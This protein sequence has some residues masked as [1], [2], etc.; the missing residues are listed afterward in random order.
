LAV[1]IDATVCVPFAQEVGMQSVASAAPSR[2]TLGTW[3]ASGVLV[4]IVGAL[5]FLLIGCDALFGL[6]D[7]VETCPEGEVK[8]GDMCQKRVAN[9]YACACA[10]SKGLSVNAVV[11]ATASVPIRQDPAG[12]VLATAT[13]GR[14]GTI[15][16]G[17]EQNDLGGTTLTWWKIHW[18]PASGLPTLPDGWSAEGNLA[19]VSSD[20]LV[21]KDFDVC[22]PASLNANVGGA[23]TPQAITNDCE[24]RVESHITALTGQEIPPTGVCACAVQ[25]VPTTW[26]AQCDGQCTND[27]DPTDTDPVCQVPA[28]APRLASAAALTVAALASESGGPPDPLAAGVFGSVS[29]CQV[30]TGGTAEITVGGK[31]P[32]KQPAVR[33]LLQIHGKPCVAEQP[34]SVG[35]SYQLTADDIEFDSESIFASDPKFVELSV[36][37]ATIP[38]AINLTRFL[39]FYT[40]TIEQN[41]AL[42]SAR[43]RRSGSTD[44]IA[45]LLRNSL[46]TGSTAAFA[47]NWETKACRLAGELGGQVLDKNGTPTDISVTLDLNGTIVNQP[48]VADTSDTNQNVECT[49]PQGAQVTLDGSKSTDRDNNIAFYTWKQGSTPVGTPSVGPK[50]VTRQNLGPKTYS[51]RVVDDEFAADTASVTVNVVDT[52]KPVIDCHLPNPATISPPSAPVSFTATATD[53]CGTPSVV[54]DNVRCFNVKSDGTRQSSQS[55]KTTTRGATITISN[56]GG[57]NNVVQWRAV[58]GDGN[59]NGQTQTCELSIVNQG[60]SK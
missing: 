54:I 56:S 50:Q 15:T 8:I 11:R 3:C 1:P 21:Q 35:L 45:T 34:C 18:D 44:N 29:V 9:H 13:S 30:T 6:D 59:G 23:A 43:A 16:L 32:I 17:P 5:A 41:A 12:A 36:E 20:V 60:L 52:T 31:A 7:L 53:T 27:N 39:G 14:Q 2:P 26:V 58:A 4:L 40:G 28:T 22:L 47:V 48:P 57:V 46:S 55:C 10:C 24:N 42:T 51:L 19:V 33:G 37:G 49:S 38:D 25:S